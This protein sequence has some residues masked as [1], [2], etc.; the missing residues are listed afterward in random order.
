MATKKNQQSWRKSHD[1]LVERAR[2]TLDSVNFVAFFEQQ[3]REI[4][5]VLAGHPGNERNF[6]GHTF[7]FGFAIAARVL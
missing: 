4:A 2:T 1:N 7:W 5:P 3:L 6:F